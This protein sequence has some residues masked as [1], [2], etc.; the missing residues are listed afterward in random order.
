MALAQCVVI[1]I[2][3]GLDVISEPTDT[4]LGQQRVEV[5]TTALCNASLDG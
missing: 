2:L 4:T 5:Q 3:K 1:R